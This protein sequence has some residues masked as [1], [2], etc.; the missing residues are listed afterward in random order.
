VQ[1][2]GLP[3]LSSVPDGV[4]GLIFNWHI[5]AKSSLRPLKVLAESGVFDRGKFSVDITAGPDVDA[6]GDH[7]GLDVEHDPETQ[8]WIHYLASH[9]QVIGSHGGWIHN[10]FGYHVNDNNE[11]EFET[12]LAMNKKAL[13]RVVGTRITEYSAPVGNHPA[14]VTRWL[15]RNGFAAYYFTGDA[16]LGPTRVFRDNERDES[17]IWAFPV[18]HMGKEASLEEMGFENVPISAVRAWLLS[19]TEF[20]VRNHTARLIYT[21]PYGAEKFFDTLRT[22]LDD[23]GT[24]ER[25][26]EFRWYTMPGLAAFLND[27]DSVHW[28]LARVSGNKVILRASHPQSLAHQTWTFP[29]NVYSN[30]RVVEGDAT[31]RVQDGMIFVDA[32]EGHQLTVELSRTPHPAPSKTFEAKR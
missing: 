16:G 6:F 15:E 18:L 32:D 17:E 14:W 1:M 23:A 12:Y 13:E 26:G 8:K 27:R 31:V 2:V 9:G 10:Y 20:T 7:K 25:R 22:W 4:G 28:D 3:Y 21:H 5:D 30:P 19:V 24:L 11:S 29:Q